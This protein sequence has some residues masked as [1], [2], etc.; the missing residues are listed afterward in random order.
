MSGP[1]REVSHG[2]AF[3]HQH[4]WS[5]NG[6]SSVPMWD[7][8]D[9]ER[10][11]PPLPFPPGANSPTTRGNTSAGIAAA[12][13]RI[14][15]ASRESAPLSSY[16]SNVTPQG[17]PERSLVKGAHHKRMQSLQTTSV[18]DLRSYLDSNR[19]PER[20]PERPTS[21]G[22]L[23]NL[24]RQQSADDVSTIDHSST[25]TPAAREPMK[26]TPTLRSST[27][28]PPRPLLGEN[29]PPSATMLALQM[30]QVPDQPFSDITNGP[31]TPSPMRVNPQYDLSAQLKD[32][33]TI[34][35]SLQKEMT[36]LNRRSKDNAIDLISLKE[37][38]TQRDEDIRT[39]LRELKNHVRT[40]GHLPAPPSSFGTNFLDSKPF[41]SPPSASKAW[42]VPRA[43]SAHSFLD[44]G[45]LGS[46]SPYS[47]EG[48]ASVA[49]LEKIIREMVT[50]EGQDRLQSC[51]SELL[52]KSRKENTD[53][54]KKVEEL[55]EFI[56]EKS[57]SQAL[58][59]M[60]K[61]G[62]PK[63]ELNFDSPGNLKVRRETDPKAPKDDEV[64]KLLTK[65]KESVAH[66]GGSTNEV[67]GLVRDLRGEVL[68]MGRD[69][70][71]K[72]GQVAETQLNS[73]LDKGIEDGQSQQ[74]AE[75]VQRIVEEGMAELKEHLSSILQQRAEQDDNAFKQ[76]AVTRS[77]PD[78][79][80]MLSM[81]KH[82]L[83]EHSS[84]IVKTEPP[85]EEIDRKLDQEAILDAVKEGLKD[86]EPNIEL[87]Q[88]G[89]ERDEVLNVLKEGL[90]DY[91]ANRPEP[92][93]AVA[94]IDK[95]EIFEVMQEALKDFQAPVPAEAINQMTEAILNNVRQ[96]LAEHQPIVAA[97]A[98]DN[99]AI[100]A[101]VVAAVKEGLSAHG[102]AAPRELE[103]SRDDLFE[104]VKASMDGSAIP[105][106]SFGEQVVQKMRELVENM[107]T[108]FQQYSAAN[109]RDTEQVLDAVK[110]GLESLRA[111]IEQY[112]DRAQD[113]TGKDEIVDTVKGG[114]EQLRADV[115]GYVQAGPSHDGGKQEML[116]YIKAE[117]EHLH[118][119][120]ANSEASRDVD[121]GSKPH[122]T[123]EIVL[124]ITEGMTA[125]KEH[126]NEK[127]REFEIE[128]PTEEINDA[129][130][131]ELEQLKA[132]VLNA[133]AANKSELIETI[134]DSM[135][136]LHAKLNG[137]ELS[138]LSGGASEEIIEEM[139]TEFA[140]L[141]ETVQAIV[142]DADRDAIV[143]SIK[144]AIDD[145]RTQL[146]AEQSEASAEAVG[147]LKEELEK[148]KETLGSSLVL[149][150]AS[151]SSEHGEVLTGIR[152]ALD[153]IKDTTA[154]R[155]TSG[156]G[157]PAELLE[158]MRGE[159]ENLRN[160][161]ATSMVHGGSNEEV[162]DAIRL[163]LDD[164]RSHVEKKLDSPDR[165]QAQQSEML[166]AINEGLESLRTDVVK[167]LDKPLDMTVNYEILDTLKGGL[168]E[169]RAG[170]DAL[171]SGGAVQPD[172][173]KGGEI[174]LADPSA[175][176]ARELSG[177]DVGAAPGPGAVEHLKAPDLER[178]EVLLAQ[179]QIKVEA[180]DAK[181]EELPTRD[182]APAQPAEDV[183]TKE[184]LATLEAMIKDVQDNI[185]TLAAREPA[186][187]PDAAPEGVA[188]KED[189]DAIETLLRNFKAQLDEMVLPDPS[190]AV[191]KEQLDA[192]EAV[193]RVTQ[194][195]IDGLADRLENSTAAKADVAVVEVL[196]QDVKT[197]LE[198]IKDKMSAAAEQ[199]KPD[200]MTKAD[201]DVLGVLCTEIKTKM[202]EMKLPNPEE[203]PSKADV[204]Q[205]QGL[206]ADFRESHDKLKD[207]YETD[208][209]VTAKAFDDRK[210]EF[211]DT[212]K[213]IAGIK[214]ALGGFKDEL[215]GKIGDSETGINTLGETLKGLEEKA[216][217][218][219]E[220]VVA[221]VKEVLEALN[222]EFERAHGSLEAMKVD[223]QQSSETA[224]EKQA[225]YKEGLVSTL[226]EK[227]DA[228]FD[229]LM[230]KY[231]DAQHAA[232]EKVK[233]MEEKSASQA[234]LMESTKSM[235][236]EL[237]LSID[238]LGST[239]TTFAETFPEKM[240]AL[241][242]ESKTV[243]GKVEETAVKLDEMTGGLKGEH[244]TTRD[245]V[246]KVLAA[247][248]G[249]QNDLGENHPRFI[250]TLEEVKAL[251]GQHY[252]HSQKA[253][254][255][256][257]E[258]HQAVRELQE[259]LKQGFEDTKARHDTSTED[260]K[261]AIPALLPPPAE[262]PAPVEVEKY[263]DTALH[264]KLDK[265]MGH[266]EA[267]AEPTAQIERLDQ[268]HE[269]VMATAA[270]VSAFVAAQTRQITE[271]HENKEKEAEEIALLLERRIVQKDE[272][273]D[274][275]TVLNEEKD[276][277]RQAVEALRAE[278]EALASQK[279]RLQAD[280]SSLET[281][282]HIRR[283]ELHEM[284]S[285]A[286]AIERRMLEGV[287]NQ[288]RMLLLAKST[289][290]A[291]QKPK[292]PQ[293]RDLRIPSNASGTSHQTV[294]STVP[295]LAKANH[296]L[297]MKTRP[298]ILR[299]GP[300]PNSAERRIMSLNE[301][302][303]NQGRS[304][305]AFS[306]ATPS[307]VSNSSKSLKRSQSVK[308]PQRNLSW[309]GKRKFTQ[310]SGGNKENDISSVS[311]ES[312]DEL[313]R[314]EELHSNAE[315]EDA[316]S[317]ATE[318]RHSYLSGTG[319]SLTYG[320]G[321]YADGETPGTDDG[322]RTSYGTSDLSYGTGS[323]MTGSDVSGGRDSLAS[324]SAAGV[325]GVESA[326]GED[327]REEE[328]E[329]EEDGEAAE[330]LQLEAPR[331]PADDGISERDHAV[332]TQFA[333]PSDSGLG[334]DLPTAALSATEGDYFRSEAE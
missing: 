222:R 272:I 210:Q 183:L 225:E 34:T 184:D 181:V 159:F 6:R 175:E 129:L 123:A 242:E 309:G 270:E 305:Q 283:E 27:R 204:E 227:L 121:G 76:L 7:S 287:M 107:H 59:A 314:D 73:S 246:A 96:A 299:N 103:I 14:V 82:A 191:T 111:Q 149:G 38:T 282:L 217:N 131:E 19:S 317:E 68:G 192:V 132:A 137:S 253:A 316:N 146:S 24:S 329:G 213:E 208:I 209:A 22:G 290:P 328:S 169:L 93:P 125:L 173:P 187:V 301:I 128:F 237:R 31:S 25:P 83:A 327:P 298:G 142:A 127:N 20:L 55:S 108:E 163:G 156:D 95:G 275:I 214:E 308:Q 312:E 157:V 122:H 57:Q 167:T 166:D 279:S 69:L 248:D 203:L 11:P 13:K 190:T 326:I 88:Y 62:P 135:G 174:V 138:N 120:V 78:S 321:S 39:T 264:E 54:A 147:A 85:V 110:D 53:A 65:I 281:A 215:I 280:V 158:A 263:D 325:V 134:Q 256:A 42:T 211:E 254:D 80:E 234:E 70:G 241:S 201:F 97:A 36:G 171:K 151:S 223:H 26:D 260:L 216:G 304:A 243:F 185:I 2:D 220:P 189:T 37:A 58:V 33:L 257:A 49:M 48:A 198:E 43:A 46:P 81:V 119:A 333:P 126:I 331:T 72:L 143:S 106:G 278:K 153:E 30:M 221:E 91:Q 265:L 112:V 219:H 160:S 17:S 56:K 226:T 161:I 99:E 255:T 52:E 139:R 235:A 205:L 277:L 302:S 92:E 162:L 297:A 66:T 77:G 98:V 318:R 115:Q 178:L 60:S 249:V 63:L 1:E 197:A 152:G 240:D 300:V 23:S 224:L 252:E 212:V 145:L 295:P 28:P 311:E 45:R 109:G 296:A 44:D 3:K 177:A 259:Q 182:Q 64:A 251:I 218:A 289:K 100:H 15:E 231:D 332:K 61:D 207:S 117:F 79:E 140:A 188:K 202:E 90:L 29:T 124:A 310:P 193:I 5:E 294:T 114:L 170:L 51:L 306:T 276:S 322:R 144:G 258:H 267:A 195:G 12:A 50:K 334:T 245:E 84:N 268:I 86:F 262:M 230:S 21:R 101:Q 247:I 176:A 269:K 239:L 47:V 89:L 148:L 291:A 273:E 284:D 105:F 330:P 261:S 74:H 10:A 244:A 199:E 133:N 40:T 250:V 118:E 271:D 116:G 266:A 41:N 8:S 324:S 150:S 238:T 168:A 164:L 172:M 288:S 18:K 4:S 75:E 71:R 200:L 130:K 323:Y 136:A 16:T 154:A 94:T 194:E 32:L 292:K 113:V 155:S 104:A 319:T 186:V 229:G 320:D 274:D 102:P 307:L 236:E 303:H 67:K 87:Q 141:K 228:L 9:P 179:V 286:E 165:N 35:T 285:K 206:I 313:A 180:M 293:G 233:T 196:A 315:H 232:E